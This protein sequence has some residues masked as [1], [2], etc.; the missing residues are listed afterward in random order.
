MV[1]IILLFKLRI[2]CSIVV[3]SRSKVTFIN[4]PRTCN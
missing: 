4:K 1:A 2:A 3:L